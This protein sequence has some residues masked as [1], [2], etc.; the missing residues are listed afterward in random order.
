MVYMILNC[1]YNKISHEFLNSSAILVILFS[2][3]TATHLVCSSWYWKVISETFIGIFIFFLEDLWRSEILIKVSSH[4]LTIWI[5][6]AKKRSVH[7]DWIFVFLSCMKNLISKIYFFLFLN[8][9][10]ILLINVMIENP[11]Y[12]SV[13]PF[14]KSWITTHEQLQENNITFLCHSHSSNSP[15]NSYVYFFPLYYE[16]SWKMSKKFARLFKFT[17]KYNVVFSTR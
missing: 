8:S 13:L 10:S 7:T 15:I 16:S 17:T 12:H 9:L 14:L 3:T 6:L 11:S 4:F 1:N 5:C 2:R